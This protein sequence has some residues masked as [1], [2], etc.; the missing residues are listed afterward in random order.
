MLK[1]KFEHDDSS[2]KAQKVFTDRTGPR[3]VFSDSIDS[4]IGESAP[5]KPGEIIVYYGKGGIGKTALLNELKA[6]ENEYYSKYPDYNFHSAIIYLDAYDYS[7]PINIL[8]AIRDKVHGDC[9]LFDY[10]MLQYCAKA[11]YSIEEV[12]R[13][14]D[15]LS[16]PLA[17]ILN[18]AVQLCTLSAC[19]PLNALKKARSIIKSNR[20]KKEYSDEIK[21]IDNYSSTE[22]YDRLPYYLGLCINNDSFDGH[23]H[24][25]FFDSYECLIARTDTVFYEAC[26]EWLKELFLSSKNIRI[27]ICSRDR[28]QWDLK[29]PEWGEY[30]N[31]HRLE[32]LTEADSRWFLG[33]VPITDEKVINKIIANAEGVPL[34]LDICVNMYVNCKNSGKSFSLN[35][36]ITGEKL[37]DRYIKHLSKK[38]KLAIRALSVLGCFDISHGL[39]LLSKQKINYEEDEFIDFMR[40]SIFVPLDESNKTWEID[41]SVRNHQL[42]PLSDEQLSSII[43]S[44]LEMI[45]EKPNGNNYRYLDNVLN[46]IECNPSIINSLIELLIE[47]IEVYG[48]SGFWEE[49]HIKL[50]DHIEDP[51]PYFSTIAVFSEIIFLRRTGKLESEHQ[52]IENHPIKDEYLGKW[53]YLYKYYRIQNIHLMGRYNEA[54]KEYKA[55]VKRM[56]LTRQLIP[57][58]IYLTVKMKYADLLFLKGQFDQAL[59]IVEELLKEPDVSEADIIE[60]FRIKGHI[61]RFRQQY[62]ES[63]IIYSEALKIAEEKSMLSYIGKLY[64]NLAECRCETSPD[65][66]INCFERSKEINER[67]DNLIELGKAYAA[68]SIAYSNMAD[69]VNAVRFA[70]RSLELSKSSGYRSG[71]VFALVAL[72]IAYS[73]NNDIKKRKSTLTKIK[74]ETEE[75]GVYQFLYERVNKIESESHE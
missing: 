64:T 4:Y 69:F 46:L 66:A 68:V 57:S 7:N 48:T 36:E 43:K 24:V 2:F 11:N 26:D 28:L 31:Q 5:K 8:L 32:N 40:R 16:A 53:K 42:A 34:Y 65:A 62:A 49:I 14:H 27:V 25:L 63:D 35:P 17:E 59:A 45:I 23:Y 37:I 47:A 30:L 60:L 21:A 75:L 58:H 44:L 73:K 67:T 18:E 51:N 13:K 71:G 20:L 3:Q 72:Y 10:A 29:E 39:N 12:M 61:F 1:S 6:H 38:E 54:L 74:K 33:K 55:L 19:I 15:L 41:K 70:N 9:G 22:I 50:N 52:F 56:D